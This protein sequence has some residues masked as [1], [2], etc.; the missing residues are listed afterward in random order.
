[1]ALPVDAVVE[2]NLVLQTT[3]HQDDVRHFV[4]NELN[5]VVMADKNRPPLFLTLGEISLERK[6]YCARIGPV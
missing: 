3:V 4:D 1:M 5:L 6:A 2:N